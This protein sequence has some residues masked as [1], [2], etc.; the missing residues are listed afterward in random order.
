MNDDH[1]ISSP[2]EYQELLGSL[3]K[4]E[5]LILSREKY[6]ELY[7]ILEKWNSSDVFHLPDFR[8]GLTAED[9]PDTLDP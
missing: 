1:H 8:D 7:A 6:P 2:E 4:R 5:D 9:D 3:P